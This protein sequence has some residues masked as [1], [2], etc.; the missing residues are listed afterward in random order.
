MKD[1]YFKNIF[2]FTIFKRTVA[3]FFQTSLSLISIKTLS[4]WILKILKRCG[5]Y[6][7]FGIY[8][9]PNCEI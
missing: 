2:M 1:T 7:D 9:L 5:K 4:T 3:Y 8:R 6:V